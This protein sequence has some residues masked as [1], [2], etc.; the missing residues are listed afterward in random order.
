MNIEKINQITGDLMKA[1]EASVK[2]QKLAAK[3][4]EDKGDLN[5]KLAVE[6]PPSHRQNVGKPLPEVYFLEPG[7][8]VIFSSRDMFDPPPPVQQYSAPAKT[9]FEQE[10]IP[11]QLAMIMLQ[12][13]ITY[14]NDRTRELRKE[15]QA[16]LNSINPLD[17]E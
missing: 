15:L 10:H 3:I 7:Q 4:A 11:H 14:Y 5:I 2:I 13:M 17:F 16:E 1:Q 12:S 8:Q 6:L 9:G